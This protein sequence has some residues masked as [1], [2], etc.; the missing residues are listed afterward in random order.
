MD[1]LTRL[2]NR[3]GAA[4]LLKAAV[5]R[6]DRDATHLTLALL[7]L[8]NFKRINDA[9]GHQIGDEVLRKTAARLTAAVRAADIVCRIGGDEFLIVMVDAD[10][11]TAAPVAE[12]VRR[13]VTETSVATRQGALPTSVSV[14]CTVRAPHDKIAADGLIERADKALLESRAGGRNRV[15]ITT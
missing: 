14:G 5:D 10:A 6:A 4:V 13:T 11:R 7:D 12:R 15:R 2:W 1:P 8:D 9:Y 3:R